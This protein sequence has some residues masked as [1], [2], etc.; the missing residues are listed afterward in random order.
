MAAYLGAQKSNLEL[1]NWEAHSIPTHVDFDKEKA[2]ALRID[3]E[4]RE[5]K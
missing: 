3:V 1:V 2:D 5:S 4:R